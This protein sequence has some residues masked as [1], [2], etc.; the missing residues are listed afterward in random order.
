MS[1]RLWS[2][3][4]VGVAHLLHYLDRANPVAV[5]VAL[6]E[7]NDDHVEVPRCDGLREPSASQR[8]AGCFVVSEREIQLGVRTAPTEHY[9]LERI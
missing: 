5:A 1:S 4:V 2:A 3:F 6:V 8:V 9:Q 7:L